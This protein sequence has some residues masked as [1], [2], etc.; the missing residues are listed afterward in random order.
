MTTNINRFETFLSSI[1]PSRSQIEDFAEAHTKLRERFQQ[2]ESIKAIHIGDFLQGSYRRYTAIRPI[3]GRKSDVDIVIVTDLDKEDTSVDELKNQFIQF[4]KSYEDYRGSI[5]DSKAHAIGLGVGD[6]EMDLVVT[7]TP[8]TINLESIRSEIS[9]T[10]QAITRDTDFWDSLTSDPLTIERS[11]NND[12]WKHDPLII[13]NFQTGDWDET[14]PLTQIQWSHDH[15]MQCNGHFV[16]VVKVLKWWKREMAPKPKH[17]KSFP[18]EHVLGEYCEP[19]I[20]SVAEGVWKTLQA[21]TDC[22]TL[23]YHLQ[24]GTVPTFRDRGIDTKDVWHRICFEDFEAFMD[25]I[26]AASSLAKLAYYEQDSANSACIW[27]ELLGPKFPTPD[28]CSSREINRG[29]FVRPRSVARPNR[30]TF[31]KGTV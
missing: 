10:K 23:N 19:G 18:L 16:N 20:N 9:V 28:D 5:D 17:P 4:L 24:S 11:A 21:M 27:G 30:G 7:L 13:P 29:G 15:N 14:D 3:A 25:E 26:A 1:R 31:G 6:V 8:S 2:N 12:S 22:P